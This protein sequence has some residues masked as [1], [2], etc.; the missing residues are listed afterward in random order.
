VIEVNV[1]VGDRGV[2]MTFTKLLIVAIAIVISLY[3][4]PV[5]A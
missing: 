2:A 4:A 1:V 3:V 5:G